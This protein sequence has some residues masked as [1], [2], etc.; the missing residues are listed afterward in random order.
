MAKNATVGDLGDLLVQNG[1]ISA[2]Q[3]SE[4]QRRRREEEK[5]LGRV[6][7]EMGA[8]DED[9]KLALLKKRFGYE[10]VSIEDFEIDPAVLALLPR[11]F[12]ERHMA[13]P[14]L[15]ERNSLV[16]AMEDPSDVVIIDEAQGL[17]AMEV[18]PVIASCRDILE[19]LQQ[20]PRAQ[21]IPESKTKAER[22]ESFG[23]FVAF[24]ILSVLP[25]PVFFIMLAFWQSFQHFYMTQVTSTNFERGLFF[26]LSWSIWAVTLYEVDGLFFSRAGSED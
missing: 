24:F 7:Y 6:L 5:S 25:I 12:C 17:L 18:Q 10:V 9:Q 15:K 13:L 8:L 14:I 21:E 3:L 16:L 19:G 2:G 11:G 20:Y 1:L 23:H 22:R 4:A 26:F